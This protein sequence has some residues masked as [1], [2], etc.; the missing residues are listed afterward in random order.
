MRYSLCIATDQVLEMLRRWVLK[1]VN[2]T[3]REVDAMRMKAA[4]QLREFA[5]AVKALANDETLSREQLGEKLCLLADDVL[6]P[7]PTSRRSQ[8]R[9][10][11]VRKRYYA[12]NL[13]N[14]IVQLPFDVRSSV[15]LAAR[16]LNSSASKR[17]RVRT[18]IPDV[19]ALR[20][21][22]STGL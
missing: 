21:L 20:P 12:R 4:D 6:Q 17:K 10:C 1:V 8:I 19:T 5:L 9:Q 16:R 18:T 22:N 15:A 2:D 14:R 7:H 13:L 3:S 11:L